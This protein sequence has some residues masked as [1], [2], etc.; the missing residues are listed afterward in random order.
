MKKL[1]KAYIHPSAA[2]TLKAK[3]IK[4]Y[5]HIDKKPEIGDVVFGEVD[6]LGQH[7]TLE[8][9]SGRIHNIHTGSKAIFVFGNRYAADYYEGVLPDYFNRYTN[10]LARSG[11]IGKVIS[12]NEKVKDATNIKLLGYC[13]DSNGEIINT[14][15]YT[16]I[17][18]ADKQTNSNKKRAKL[19]LI[20]GTSMNAGKSSTAGACVWSL[21]SM[22]HNVRG[23]KI[24]GTASLKDILLMNDRGAEI[25]NDFSYLGYPST[26]M[27]PKEEVIGIFDKIDRKIGNNSKN[28][29]VV[30]IA[31]GILQRE[32]KM[33]LEEEKIRN[34]IHKL[35]FAAGDAFGAL[36]G[37]GI[38]KEKYNLVP[39]AI[40]GVCSSSPLHIRELQEFT[41]IPIFNSEAPDLAQ[42]SKILI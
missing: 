17:S 11:L 2:F 10:L 29:W 1:P 33:L 36:G 14:K 12:K 34:R 8:N 4:G 3:D 22:G 31:D 20:V 16:K 30:E 18:L 6:R 37:I 25:Y 38:L 19:I 7:S 21:A 32:T 24:T 42:L 39:D 5:A 28:Y 26:Y 27:V 40:S 35:I 15:N 13:V 9:I 23:S 41:D